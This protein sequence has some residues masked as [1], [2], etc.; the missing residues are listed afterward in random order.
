MLLSELLVHLDNLGWAT[1]SNEVESIISEMS[2]EGL[3]QGLS[4]LEGGALL[5]EF[6]PV[7]LTDDPQLVL[8]LAAER[9][10][11]LSFEDVVVGLNWTEERARNALSLLVETGVAKEQRSYSRST[12]YWFPGLRRGKK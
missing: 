3:I 7:A 10:G 9:E 11:N 6:V 2:G 4:T 8:G 1:D 5:V 12:Q